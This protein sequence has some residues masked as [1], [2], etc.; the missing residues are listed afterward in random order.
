MWVGQPFLT[1]ILHSD[2]GIW[3]PCILWC[4][5]LNH[6]VT[7]DAMGGEGRACTG[8]QGVAARSGCSINHF[9]WTAYW[10]ELYYMILLIQTSFHRA[11]IACTGKAR[12]ENGIVELYPF[13]VTRPKVHLQP[14]PLSPAIGSTCFIFSGHFRLN[15]FELDLNYSFPPSKVEIAFACW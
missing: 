15:L 14:P 10:P 12:I 5:H 13:S 7:V 2:L 8:L 4:C 9:R 3:E 11:S 1:A 6:E